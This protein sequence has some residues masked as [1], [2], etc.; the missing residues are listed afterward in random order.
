MVDGAFGIQEHQSYCTKQSPLSNE[1]PSLKPT[2]AIQRKK[3]IKIKS[4]YHVLV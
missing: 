3:K 1:T 2:A 4:H